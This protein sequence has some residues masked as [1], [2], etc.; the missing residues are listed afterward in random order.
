[1]RI[2]PGANPY[3][4]RLRPSSQL[5]LESSASAALRAPWRGSPEEEELGRGA[6][7]S[8]VAQPARGETVLIRFGSTG[9]S[10]ASQP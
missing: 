1:M 7:P 3:R 2:G 8:D 9:K 6:R 5:A 10:G 4:L